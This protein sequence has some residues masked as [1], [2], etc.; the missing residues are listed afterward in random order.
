MPTITS[1]ATVYDIY[2]RVTFFFKQAVPF[3]AAGLRQVT[4]PF[5]ITRHL[6]TINSNGTSC[7]HVSALELK[8]GLNFRYRWLTAS[9]SEVWYIALRFCHYR[10]KYRFKAL[11]NPLPELFFSSVRPR[12][13]Y[14]RRRSLNTE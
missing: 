1:Y 3:R 10:R 12:S 2:F 9:G 8:Y 13:N 14:C 4:S 5:F 11:K 7:H 6:Y